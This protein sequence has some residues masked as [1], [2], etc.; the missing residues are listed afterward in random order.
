MALQLHTLYMAARTVPSS[1][2]VTNSLR[3]DLLTQ[4]LRTRARRAVDLVANPATMSNKIVQLLL[5]IKYVII[6]YL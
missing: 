1:S 5:S 6:L 3:L 2:A 4:I